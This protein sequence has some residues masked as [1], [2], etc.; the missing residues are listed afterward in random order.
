MQSDKLVS[1]SLKGYRRWWHWTDSHDRT[2]D[3]L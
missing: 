3:V 1:T 2:W